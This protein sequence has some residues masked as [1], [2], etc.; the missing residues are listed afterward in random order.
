MG[1]CC[2]ERQCP[3]GALAKGAYSAVSMAVSLALL[4]TM[5]ALGADALEPNKYDVMQLA[6]ITNPDAWRN[7]TQDVPVSSSS[8][9][10]LNLAS[11]ATA[12]ESGALICYGKSHQ[13]V[14]RFHTSAQTASCNKYAIPLPSELIRHGTTSNPPPVCAAA[15]SACSE[16]NAG[17]MDG[18]SR[19]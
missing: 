15:D 4:M 3:T 11:I 1:F 5:L 14:E 9:A 7:F 8:I 18:Q 17:G 13:H 16:D 10:S 2:S 6:A 12:G 19:R